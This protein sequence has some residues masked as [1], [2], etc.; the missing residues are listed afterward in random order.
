MLELMLSRLVMSICAMLVLLALAPLCVQL[1]SGIAGQPDATLD[2][3]ESR[4]EEVAAAP[5]EAT[6]AIEM[7][8]YLEEGD[9]LLLYP[10]ALSLVGND[11]QSIRPLP[12]EFRITM[13]HGDEEHVLDKAVLDQH[14]SLYL[15]KHRSADGMTLEAHIEN[16]AATSA[17]FSPNTSTS[18]RVL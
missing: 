13:A 18:A 7:G 1:P 11:G 14:S 15:S 16:L 17:T 5:G 3:L 6:L 10:S 2:E 9:L 4:F 8:D 12:G